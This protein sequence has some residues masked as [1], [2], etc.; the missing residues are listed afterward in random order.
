M[1]FCGECGAPLQAEAPRSREDTAE[2]RQLTVM[3]CDLA[4]STALAERLDVEELRE[5]VRD[6]QEVC[7]DV[8]Q[9]FGGTIAQYLGD[10]LLVYFG[11]PE[12][13]EDDA[14]RAARSALDI[15]GAIG[16]LSERLE[17]QRGFRLA[18]RTGIH[19]GLV[20]AGEVG[21]GGK[22]EQLALGQTPN[23]AAR[24]QALAEPN[25][26]VVS[27]TVL[28][29]IE[30][31]F[32][33]ESLGER[34]LKGLTQ[35]TAV[36]RLLAERVAP[37]RF[38]GAGRLSLVGRDREMAALV[39]G[40]E[41]A[42]SG[43]GHVALVSGGAGIGKSLLTHKLKEHTASDRCTW[44]V[45]RCSS[46]YADSPFEPLIDLLHRALPVDPRGSP[47]RKLQQLETGLGSV[48][49]RVKEA[50]P[51]FADFLSIPLSN[52]YVPPAMT[53]QRMKEK[54]LELL[55]A[56]LRALAARGP[57]V[58][59]VEDIHW[60]DPSTLEF[61]DQLVQ[62]A[63]GTRML[64]LVT[65]RPQLVPPWVEQPHVT[66]IILEQLTDDQVRDVVE[67]ITGGK[68]L[69]AE[70]L[71][72]ITGKTD[73][74]PLFVE[75][76]TKA[77]LEAD[78]LRETDRHYELTGP[79]SSLAIPTTLQDSLM[80]RLDRLATGKDVAQLAA[81]LGREF[82]FE[83]LSAVSPV[84]DEVLRHSLDRLVSAQLLVQRGTSLDA[85]FVFRHALI[86]DAAYQSLL[87]ATR[88]QHHGTVAKILDE[89]FPEVRRTQPEVLAY[90]CTEAGLNEPAVDSWIQAGRLAVS[91][92]TNREAVRHLQR[93]LE[94]IDALPATPEQ[95]HR[96]LVLQNT[97]G[98]ARTP[99]YGYAAPEV[100]QAYGRAGE[101]AEALGDTPHLFWV[102]WGLS[103]FH[104]VRANLDKSLELTQRMVRLARLQD[105]PVVRREAHSALGSTLYFR[106]EFVAAHG[107][108]EAGLAD[109]L[110]DGHLDPD[111]ELP[112][113]TSE[114]LAGA[115]HELVTCLCTESLVLWH[116]GYPD[117]ALARSDSAIAVARKTMS[118]HNL[119]W[120]L[121][122]T[123]RLHASRG[124]PDLS[125]A[126]AQE[127]I[128]LSQEHGL[129]WITQ[130]NFFR[131]RALAAAHRPEADEEPLAEAFAL[132]RLGIDGFRTPGAKVSQTYMLAQLADVD[133]NRG[134]VADAAQT[135][136]EAHAA[137][138]AT[139][140]R[141]W[142]AELRRLDGEV[143]LAQG[144]RNGAAVAFQQALETAQAQRCKA[145]ELRAA[146]RL[147]RLWTE[148]GRRDEARP[149]LGD[150]YGWFGEGLETVDLKRAKALLEQW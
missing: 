133:L 134:A 77:I 105:D 13:H 94:L 14:R 39:S 38:E 90:H 93:G 11:F 70:V 122:Y 103:T 149:L 128:D 136:E 125:R 45:A 119:G 114:H 106:G 55:H 110:P 36:Y 124:E 29:L 32:D 37:S 44:L 96:E 30:D 27:G 18:V 91:R 79:L 25:T 47:D 46:Y 139:G 19:T 137:L 127:V 1:K 66:S 65:T 49:L 20:V 121:T 8:V 92:G 78:L 4:E 76:L 86:Q 148:Q 74:V 140:E 147:G 33:C 3:F 16:H 52:G 41:R 141:Y 50:V 126:R 17:S 132:M 62:H 111:T 116:L 118:P 6:Y 67:G 80:A 81:V 97:L 71:H 73:G 101:L 85:T 61:V 48:G 146:M 35:P 115:Y 88:Q 89:R 2:R 31:F 26:V 100:E 63:P 135:L 43:E 59:V 60:A 130:G 34:Q 7:G 109:A 5:V 107:H 21:G 69:P 123:A 68:A 40:F 131:G 108:L 113:P 57:V 75:E 58:F 142:E 87:K 64:A 150:V 95:Q 112:T 72:H 22:R 56:M 98:A 82:T 28:R 54:T 9:R 143:A 117:Q 23:I 84:A 10:G 99:L 15:T 51:L 129:F 102:L 24:L 145:F 42:S 83:L 120:A 138:K 12:A 53:P 104:V 144:D